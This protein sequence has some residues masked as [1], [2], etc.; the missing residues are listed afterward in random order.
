MIREAAKNLSR[1]GMNPVAF[2]GEVLTPLSLLQTPLQNLS[3]VLTQHKRTKIAGVAPYI[4]FYQEQKKKSWGCFWPLPLF[5]KFMYVAEKRNNQ[6]TKKNQLQKKDL[7]A[8]K[9]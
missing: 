9:I 3:S 7:I 8:E 5:E 4:M 1:G 6:L 2:G